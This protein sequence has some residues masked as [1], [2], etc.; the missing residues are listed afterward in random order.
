MLIREVKSDDVD[1]QWLSD[2]QERARDGWYALALS[3]FL[4]WM[5]PQ[6]EQLKRED[7]IRQEQEK[8]RDE[9]AKELKK[10][11]ANV[12]ERTPSAMAEY[13]LGFEK[14]VEFALYV[15]A[16]DER[17]ATELK[18]TCSSVLLDIAYDQ[19]AFIRTE[20]PTTQFIALLQAAIGGGY[21]HVSDVKEYDVAPEGVQASWGWRFENQWR[22]N[23]KCIGWL[24]GMELFLEPNVAFCNCAG[25]CQ[26]SRHNNS[27]F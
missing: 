26:T 1:L 6:M 13:Y 25:D 14:F 22:P 12:H 21:A 7:T 15:R 11:H 17:R 16:I 8:R 4:R 2:A 18:E 23:G 19:V 3:G 10:K 9:F 24:D 5:A 27:A 20:E